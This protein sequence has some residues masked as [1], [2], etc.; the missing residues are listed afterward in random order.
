MCC[1]KPLFPSPVPQLQH[2]IWSPST[3]T[4]AAQW[5]GILWKRLPSSFWGIASHSCT[6]TCRSCCSVLGVWKH[7]EICQPRAYQTCSR[8]FR[9]GEQAGHSFCLISSVSR[10]SPTMAAWWGCVLSS[11]R[12][13]VGP[14]APLESQTHWCKMTSYIWPVTVPLSKTCRGVCAPSII[15][16]PHHQTTT[17]LQFPFKDIT[18][19]VSGSWYMTDENPPR[20]T[21]QPKPIFVLEHNLGP[22]FQWPCTVFLTP[23]FMGSPVTRC[24]RN[25]PC[26]SPG[27]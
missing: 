2:R 20:I 12:R 11:I 4:Q 7:A 21:V 14:T 18:G 23:G 3:H 25:A 26:R 10:Y 15:P 1:K 17:S 13:K 16:P 5:V 6:S 19:L 8:G 27:E 24:Q 9:S 22:L